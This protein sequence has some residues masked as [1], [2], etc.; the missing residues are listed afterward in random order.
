MVTKL[1]IYFEGDARLRPGFRQF[2]SEIANAAS[3]KKCQFDLIATDGTPVQ[4]FRDAMKTH[5]EAWNVLVLD[6][7]LGRTAVEGCDPESIFWMVQIMESWLLVDIDA[8][9]RFYN[10]GFQES[11]LKGNPNVEQIPK[12]DVLTRLKKATSETKS[13]EYHKIK[14]APK[15]LQE[16]DPV[17]VRRFAPNCDRRFRLILAALG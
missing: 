1:R 2:L 10:G 6:S 12:A 8:L 15:L 5:P 17:L 13:G 11:A 16:I 9:K 7:D 4:D 14:H 3:G